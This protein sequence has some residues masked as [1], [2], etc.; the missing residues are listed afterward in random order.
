[1]AAALGAIEAP[2]TPSFA[3][4]ALVAVLQLV[5]VIHR[6]VLIPRHSEKWRNI[7]ADKHLPSSQGKGGAPVW[8]VH[9]SPL[10]SCEVWRWWQTNRQI[11]GRP[12]KC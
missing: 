2:R 3:K 11:W 1:M 7:G 12:L 9:F 4:L 6:I 5:L 10:H 8:S